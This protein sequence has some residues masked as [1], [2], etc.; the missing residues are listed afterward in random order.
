MYKVVYNA[1]FGGFT[2][3]EDAVRLA[4]EMAG[5]H[6]AWNEI[7]EEYG[8]LYG[9][10]KRHDAI[11]VAVVERLGGHASGSCAKLQ[12]AEIESNSYRIDEYDGYESVE[13]PAD[14]EW[15]IIK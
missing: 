5:D 10:I 4:K 11:L 9:D 7:S 14:I 3:S 2:L 12:I 6:P 15:T 8:N 13:T 1:C